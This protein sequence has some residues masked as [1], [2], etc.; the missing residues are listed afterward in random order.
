[1]IFFRFFRILSLFSLNKKVQQHSKLTASE[2][3]KGVILGKCVFD[4]DFL[5]KRLG[6]DL[7]EYG[8][9]F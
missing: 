2:E 6:K 5:A 1:M 9:P 3:L 8:Y 4:N 7:Q